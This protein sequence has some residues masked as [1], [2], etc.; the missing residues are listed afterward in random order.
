MKEFAGAPTGG[1]PPY[2]ATEIA[3]RD[4][5]L[6]AMALSR[7]RIA[8]NVAGQKPIAIPSWAEITRVV[9]DCRG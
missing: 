2:I 7:G 9:E 1:T 3:P 4:S 5:M 8:I 6:D